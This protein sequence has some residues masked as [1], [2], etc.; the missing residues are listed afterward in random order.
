MEGIC[1][2]EPLRNNDFVKLILIK[3][4]SELLRQRCP[5]A[6]NSQLRTPFYKDIFAVLGVVAISRKAKLA[7]QIVQNAASSLPIFDLQGASKFPVLSFLFRK[8]RNRK[9]VFHGTVVPGHGKVKW[10]TLY[11]KLDACN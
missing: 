5:M 7:N 10:E 1:K 8:I 9:T 3:R 2:K 11:A 4:G 6:A